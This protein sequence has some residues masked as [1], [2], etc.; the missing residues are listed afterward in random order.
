MTTSRRSCAAEF[1]LALQ[2]TWADATVAEAANVN[3]PGARDACRR[4]KIGT[5]MAIAIADAMRIRVTSISLAPIFTQMLKCWPLKKGRL[6]LKGGFHFQASACV[7]TGMRYV[8]AAR[9]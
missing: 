8:L 5:V 2:A 6:L 7:S 1:P 9:A 3:A 4:R